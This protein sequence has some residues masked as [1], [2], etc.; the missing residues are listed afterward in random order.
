[1]ISYAAGNNDNC[2]LINTDVGADNVGDFLH[3]A[4]VVDSNNVITTFLNGAAVSVNHP[5]AF[6]NITGGS[7]VLGQEQDT[8]GGGFN[9][10]QAANV[11]F[12]SLR[13]HNTPLTQFVIQSI[14]AGTGPGLAALRNDWCFT[15]AT[16]GED[17][18][19]EGNT[20]TISGGTCDTG[21]TTCPH[22]HIARNPCDPADSVALNDFTTR[23]TMETGGWDFFGMTDSVFDFI[24]P[25][26]TARTSFCGGTSGYVACS[27]AMPSLGRPHY[28]PPLLLRSPMQKQH[29]H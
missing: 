1:M 25:G 26:S 5:G 8:V 22:P 19:T 17:T 23:A 15:C 18:G 4:V 13:V 24:T 2:L 6:C 20:F 14:S 12:D 3:L 16:Q 28:Q 21:H 10:N 9:G 27:G 7:L 29:S 11:V